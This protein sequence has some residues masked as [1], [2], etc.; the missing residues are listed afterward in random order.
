MSLQ[1]QIKD[2]VKKLPGPMQ[3]SAEAYLNILVNSA[4]DEIEYLAMQ[5]VSNPDAA[6]ST[7]LDKLPNSQLADIL[8]ATNARM[9]Q[10]GSQQFT[11]DQVKRQI[12]VD[13]ITVGIIALRAS[14]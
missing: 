8:L 6:A 9:T 4:I 11:A 7:I 5:S 13:L 3:G 12:L 14:V 10:N 1:D 2:I